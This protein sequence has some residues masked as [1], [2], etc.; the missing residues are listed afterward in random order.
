MIRLF[1]TAT[2]QVSP[3]PQRDAGKVS[4][5][6]CGPTVYAPPH[7]GH[8]RQMLIYDILRRYLMW[9]GLEVNFVS[10]ITDID[11]NIIQRGQEEG[12]DPAEIA[13]KCEQVWWTAVDRLGVL[14]P[15]H[16]PHATEYVDQM[17]DLVARFI[18]DDAA[19]VTSDGVYL[20]VEK[21]EGYGLLAHQDLDNLV[22]GGGERTVVGSEKRHPAD[23]ALWKLAKP[24]EPEWP[25]PWGPGRPGWHTECVVM[26]L[27]ILGQGF[28]LHTGG[29]DLV[30]PHHEN[31]RAQAV[32]AGANFAQHW[33]HHGFVE[34]GGEK[35]SKSLGNVT[36]LL[37]LMDTYDPRSYRLLLLQSHYRSPIE[38]TDTTM[39]AAGAALDRLDAFGRRTADLAQGSEADASVL[40]SFTE[41]MDNDL[42]TAGAVDLMFRQVREANSALDEGDETRAGV[43]AATALEIAGVFGLAIET[44]AA[45]VPVEIEALAAE[46]SAARASKDW[47]RADAIRDELT[48]AGWTVEDGADGP[49]VRPL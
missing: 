11:D 42:D 26:S 5:Y 21:V 38:V 28:D 20:S 48:A 14:R 8:G 46:R 18:A 7:I 43:A 31:E 12:R 17:V 4:I 30:F 39:K 37:D 1:D 23:F 9:T 22:E 40:A 33:M 3:L 45:T 34:M 6:V 32:A 41:L 35:M 44:A 13:I 15:D 10:N 49:V 24:G 2:G 36:N 29:L 27:D 19:Y 25:S 47:A 16:I